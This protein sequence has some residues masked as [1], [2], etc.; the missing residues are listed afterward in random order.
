[1]YN[2]EPEPGEPLP[3]LHFEPIPQLFGIHIATEHSFLEG[4]V[5]RSGD[6]HE[7]F[8]INNLRKAAPVLES[9]LNFSGRAGAN[10]SRL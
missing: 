7:Y 8:E 9:K 1:V 6:Y 3:G 4:H 10:F 2:L 5:A